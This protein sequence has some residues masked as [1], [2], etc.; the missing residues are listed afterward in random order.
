MDGDITSEMN[1]HYSVGLLILLSVIHCWLNQVSLMQELFLI[2][3]DIITSIYI[4]FRHIQGTS[5]YSN[6]LCLSN[7]QQKGALTD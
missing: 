1:V 4:I 2:F 7:V 5:T 3:S 6:C